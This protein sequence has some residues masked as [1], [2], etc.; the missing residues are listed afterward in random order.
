MVDDEDFESLSKFRWISDNKKCTF[1]ALRISPDRIY[2]H[3]EII[4]VKNSK[5]SV[6]HIDRNGLNNQKSNLRAC[7]QSENIRNSKLSKN[8]TTGF[9]GVMLHKKSGKFMAYIRHNYKMYNLGLFLTPQEASIA[10]NEAAVRLHG[11]FAYINPS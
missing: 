8:N 6:D 3:R 5:V 1:Y 10:R 4:G 7:S 11:E 2:M 9:K